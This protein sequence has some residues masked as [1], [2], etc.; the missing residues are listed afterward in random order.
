MRESL[1]EK[2]KQMEEQDKLNQE[3]RDDPSDN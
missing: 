3:I 2:I 1:N